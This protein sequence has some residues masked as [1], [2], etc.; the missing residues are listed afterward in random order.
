MSSQNAP[1]GGKSKV[2]KTI[3][4]NGQGIQRKKKNSVEDHFYMG[5]MLVVLDKLSFCD[6]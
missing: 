1:Q 3:K 4:R 6:K 2:S 5:T